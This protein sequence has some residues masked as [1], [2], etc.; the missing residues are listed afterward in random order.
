[1]Q[2][3]IENYMTDLTRLNCVGLHDNWLQLAD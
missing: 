3:S 1:M 2:H